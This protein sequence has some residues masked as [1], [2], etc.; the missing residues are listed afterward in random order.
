MTDIR[1]RA[2]ALVALAVLG[3]CVGYAGTALGVGGPLTDRTPAAEF[4]VSDHGVTL[5]GTDETVTVVENMTGV[6][7]VEMSATDGRLAV[8]T[9]DGP[10]SP[11]DRERAKAI[12]RSDDRVRQRLAELD[13]Y[14]LAVEPIYGISA[15]RVQSTNVSLDAAGGNWTASAGNG[16]KVG[17]TGTFE[18]ENATVDSHDGSVTV[19]E[20]TY[21]GHVEVEIRNATGAVTAEAQV[22]LENEEVVVVTD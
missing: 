14:E 11:A 6:A 18:V 3:G 7:A 5:S 16:T 20:Q 10:L 8:E 4:R 9:D 19:S 13:G 22:D 15:D 21:D 17:S 1:L 2:V 12:T